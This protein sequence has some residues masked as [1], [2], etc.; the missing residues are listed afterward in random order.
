MI[1]FESQVILK[2]N[3]VRL[4]TYYALTNIGFSDAA[5]EQLL[6]M[7]DMSKEMNKYVGL[8]FDEVHIRADLV[9]D[10]HEGSLVGFVN[11]GEVNNHLMRFEGEVLGEGEL[12]QLVNSMVV[13]MV[14]HCFTILIFHMYNL[15]ETH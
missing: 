1:C 4:Y 11:L 15:P 6:R 8:V 9:F 12:K 7:A 5:D 14:R 3:F 10:K 2:E 13:F